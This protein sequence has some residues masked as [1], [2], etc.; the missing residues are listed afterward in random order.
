MLNN[1]CKVMVHKTDNELEIKGI[2]TLE[3]LYD[4]EKQI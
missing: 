2:N 1:N 3:E 4:I